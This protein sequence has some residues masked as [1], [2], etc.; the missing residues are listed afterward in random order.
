M[1]IVKIIH[2]F[3]LS[4][5]SIEML[6]RVECCILLLLEICCQFSVFI[7]FCWAHQVNHHIVHSF[8]LV[9]LFAQG[10]CPHN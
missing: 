1:V 5:S 2:Q 7:T 3:V 10:L 4:N 8:H 9:I 6:S